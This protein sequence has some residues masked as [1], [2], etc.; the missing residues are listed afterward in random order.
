MNIPDKETMANLLAHEQTCRRISAEKGCL[1]PG[2]AEGLYWLLDALRLASLA[3]SRDEAE[4]AKAELVEERSRK[5]I[6][7]WDVDDH[8]TNIS[9]PEES[10]ADNDPGFY[11][12]EFMV[13]TSLPNEWYSCII[14][15]DDEIDP[16]LFGPFKTEAEARAARAD[17]GSIGFNGLTNG[18]SR[19]QWRAKA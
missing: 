1:Y 4:K 18:P 14:S 8:E 12:R 19:P 13:A 7:L 15:E 6:M 2:D 9:D 17:A 16:V 11:V 10:F 3:A 5:G